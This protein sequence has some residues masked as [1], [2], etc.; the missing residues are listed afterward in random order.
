MPV[1]VET[2]PVGGTNCAGADFRSRAATYEAARSGE[3]PPGRPAQLGAAIDEVPPGLFTGVVYIGCTAEEIDELTFERMVWTNGIGLLVVS[4]QEWPGDGTLGGLPFGG[5]SRQAGIVQVSA[6]DTDALERTRVVHLFDGVRVVTV[7]TFSLTTMSVERVEE[8]AW[9]T[10]DGIPLDSTSRKGVGVTRGLEDLI[11]ELPS[12]QVPVGDPEG[13]EELSPF[14][15]VLGIANASYQFTAGG[16]TVGVFDFGANG[17]ASRAAAAIAPD[18]YTID[19]IPYDVDGTPRF[20]RWDRLIVEY[21]G[22]D[23]VL[24]ARLEEVIGPPFAGGVPVTG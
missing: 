24:L 4:W 12:N 8:L 20:W 13:L 16:N 22:H 1:P 23:G 14:T 21:T 7:A 3:I 9:S 15:E 19:H 2:A 18:G 5:E 6:M 11:A 10:Y 17:A